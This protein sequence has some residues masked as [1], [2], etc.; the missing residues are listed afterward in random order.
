MQ[1]VLH[2]GELKVRPGVAGSVWFS[3]AGSLVN[4]PRIFPIVVV[5]PELH[6][7]TDLLLVVDARHPASLDLRLAERRQQESGENRDDRDDHQQF[8]QR[9]AA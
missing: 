8:N 6:R 1:L 7:D 5:R 4:S 3:A 2:Q 9:E